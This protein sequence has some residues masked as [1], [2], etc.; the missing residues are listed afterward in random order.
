MC[1]EDGSGWSACRCKDSQVEIP[2]ESTP[3]EEG[4]TIE[5]SGEMPIEREKT[6]TSPDSITDASVDAP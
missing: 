1:S 6:E 4:I 5:T 3:K 2:T